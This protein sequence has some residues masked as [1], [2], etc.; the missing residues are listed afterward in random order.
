MEVNVLAVAAATAA[1]VVVGGLWYS[2]VFGN[3]WGQ[4]HGFD[5][6]SKEKQK[7]MAGKMGPFYFLQVLVTILT[8]I[9]L[10]ELVT[11]TPE[12][13]AYM[14][15]F[16]LWLGFVVPAQYSNVAFGGT[17]SKWMLKKLLILGSGSLIAL[18]V[19][20]AVLQQF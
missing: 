5:K 19:A 6:L 12:Y 20:T 14:L 18:L 1:Q 3:I 4:M 10:A 11:I 7:E 17:E 16:L 2:L 9:V 13:S 15:A 8:S